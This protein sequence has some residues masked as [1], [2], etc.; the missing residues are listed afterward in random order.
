MQKIS[1]YFLIFTVLAGINGCA[2]IDPE[3][4]KSQKKIEHYILPLE[5]HIIDTNIKYDYD[6]RKVENIVNSIRIEEARY[7]LYRDFSKNI[8]RSSDKKY[9]YACLEIKRKESLDRTM[10][11]IS[12]FTL[13][14][15]NLFGF[16]M[17]AE[18][19]EIEFELNLLNSQK[20]LIYHCTAKG[21]DTEYGALF[22]G[23]TVAGSSDVDT[24]IQQITNTKALQQALDSLKEQLEK[25]AEQINKKFLAAGPIEPRINN[26]IAVIKSDD[27]NKTSSQDRGTLIP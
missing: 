17:V 21:E 20:Q 7:I 12:A 3:I 14:T 15:I 9:G 16:P 6:T 25:D 2:S 27:L 23:Y 18:K 22:W 26:R 1:V 10:G 24:Q 13:L 19:A 8:F 5:L 4:F 11:I